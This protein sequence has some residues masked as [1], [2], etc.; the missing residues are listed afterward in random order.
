MEG[1]IESKS[2]IGYVWQAFFFFLILFFKKKKIENQFLRI[3]K[4]LSEI[5]FHKIKK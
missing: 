5:F 2:N 3:T 4:Q 1:E